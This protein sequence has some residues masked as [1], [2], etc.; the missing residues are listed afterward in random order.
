MVPL[1]Q[2][3]P[4]E[5]SSDL[6]SHLCIL[7]FQSVHFIQKFPATI[8]ASTSAQLC[9]YI[10]GDKLLLSMTTQLHTFQQCDHVQSHSAAY[11][12]F[13]NVVMAP[14]VFSPENHNGKNEK[15]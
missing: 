10:A 1:G 9:L 8:A 5:Q 3:R 12:V 14:F 2:F 6:A 13:E 4:V 7:A 15:R 11:K